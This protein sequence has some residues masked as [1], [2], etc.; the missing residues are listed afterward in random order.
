MQPFASESHSCGLLTVNPLDGDTREGPRDHGTVALASISRLAHAT[1]DYIEFVQLADFIRANVEPILVEWESFARRVWPKGAV[2]DPAEL[3]NEAG[4]ILRAAAIDMQ[5]DQSGSQ[6]AEKSKGGI[7]ENRGRDELTLASS[8]HGRG[9]G[10]RGSTCGR[11]SRN[12]ALFAPACCGCGARANAATARPGRRHAVQRVDRPVAHPRRSQ[13]RGTG[14]ARPREVLAKERRGRSRAANRAKDL[15][16]ATLSHEMRTPLNA[17]VGWISILRREDV[18]GETIPGGIGRHRAKTSTKV[19]L[20][21][22]VL[23]V[24]ASSSGKLR[25]E[26]RP[27][28]AGGCIDAGVNAVRP[29]ATRGASRWRCVSIPRAAV[30]PATR[31]ASSRSCGTW[32]PTPSSSPPRAGTSRHTEPGGVQASDRST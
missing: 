31:R 30:R 13:L 9:R 25:L 15:F 27:G 6:Q 24:R 29:A 32:F 28:R 5:S 16:L 8:S 11:W 1:S 12:T 26:M 4:D 14:G 23:D 18:E 3:R 19:Q 21:D 7:R 2:A 20:I 17:I 10:Y 22:D